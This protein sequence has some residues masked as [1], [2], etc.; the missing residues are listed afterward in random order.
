MLLAIATVILHFLVVSVIAL[1]V[2][3][4]IT[5]RFFRLSRQIRIAYY[6]LAA[7]FIVS[8]LA[9]GFCPLTLCEKYFWNR[10]NHDPY[11]GTFFDHYFPWISDFVDGNALKIM[12]VVTVIQLAVWTLGKRGAVRWRE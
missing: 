1:G 4:T 2:G 6:S 7:G 5:G 12:F 11:Q 3:S 8:D 9:L 10:Y